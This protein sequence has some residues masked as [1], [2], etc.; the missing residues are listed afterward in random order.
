MWTPVT[1]TIRPLQDHE[2]TQFQWYGEMSNRELGL[3]LDVSAIR[4]MHERAQKCGTGSVFIAHHDKRIAGFIGG[5]LRPEPLAGNIELH[6][7]FVYIL[8]FYRGTDTIKQ[9]DNTLVKWG[10]EHGAITATTG[11][12]A[13]TTDLNP[14]FTHLGYHV[15]GIIYSKEIHY[16]V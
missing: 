2:F 10:K 12:Y 4:K 14:V 7:T 1:L 8:N 16:G 6:Q 15:A 11:Q 5:I 3:K 13:T 9:L